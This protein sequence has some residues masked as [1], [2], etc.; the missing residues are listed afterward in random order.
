MEASVEYN[1]VN[2]YI[3]TQFSFM[4][5]KFYSMI[6]KPPH[7]PNLSI[8]MVTWWCGIMT[9]SRTT[10]TPEGIHEATE[11]DDDHAALHA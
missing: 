4:A 10:G 6:I 11:R 2:V 3:S 8:I 1:Q 9:G 7:P 5:S